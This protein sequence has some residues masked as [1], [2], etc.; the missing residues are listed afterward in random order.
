MKPAVQFLSAF[1]R[2][3]GTAE[4]AL[5]RVAEPGDGWLANAQPPEQAIPRIAFIRQHAE[6]TGR[7]P[8]ALG[9]QAQLGD[10]RF[11]PG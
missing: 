6:A 10:P 1:Y 8:A 11:G 9:F 2:G 5:R 4:V 3:G 7:D